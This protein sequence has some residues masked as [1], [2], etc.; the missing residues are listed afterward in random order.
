ML[1]HIF[2]RSSGQALRQKYFI[3]YSEQTV[4]ICEE[5]L[6]V[7]LFKV[8]L[9]LQTQAIKKAKCGHD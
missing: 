9:R 6:F 3:I 7:V 4:C 5:Y 2:K 1:K 8:F